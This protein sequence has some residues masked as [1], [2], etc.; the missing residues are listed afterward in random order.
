MPRNDLTTAL[1]KAILGY[2]APK[3]SKDVQ[4]LIAKFMGRQQ[5]L[6]GLPSARSES[7]LIA[8][9]P[10]TRK[11]WGQEGAGK[12]AMLNNPA[13]LAS[14]PMFRSSVPDIEAWFFN[15]REDARIECEAALRTVNR[16]VM[17][18]AMMGL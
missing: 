6:L 11:V 12:D 7:L 16:P 4:D 10:I 2:K 5:F 8:R 1:V 3:P 13:F 18:A 9:T 14:L 17:A 15:T